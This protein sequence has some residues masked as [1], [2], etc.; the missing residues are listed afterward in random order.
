MS[1]P[2]ANEILSPDKENSANNLYNY[3]YVDDQE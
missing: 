1:S 2:S 3:L